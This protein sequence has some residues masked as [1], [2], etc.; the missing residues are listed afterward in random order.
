MLSAFRRLLL[1]S[2]RTIVTNASPSAASI[3]PS[4][5]LARLCSAASAV[6][7][8]YARPLQWMHWAYAGGF[9]T[10]MGTVLASQKTTGPT[11]LG[12]KG[13]TKGTLMMIHKSTAVLLTAAFVPRLA[14]RLASAAPKALPVSS[15][16]HAAASASHFALYGFML[17]MPA[18]G[19]SMGYYGGKGVPFF[20]L[21]TIPG[22]S[23]ETKTKEDGQF[24]GQ[25]FKA[26]KQIGSVLW[27]MVPLH[28]AGAVQHA[29]RG[30]TIFTRINP[31]APRA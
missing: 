7:E 30:H 27:Y 19:M 2:A 28:I 10:V 9:L 6:E 20:G 4:S 22:K 21:Y 31:L 3:K 24:A 1:P 12:T 29:V 17:L 26:H 23:A 11:F 5:R 8:Q 13:Q 18:T 15:L 25:M 16:E 14:L